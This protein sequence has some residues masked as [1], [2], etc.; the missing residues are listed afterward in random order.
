MKKARLI[1]T[2]PKMVIATE[3]LLC[4]EIINPH[5]LSL[6]HLSFLYVGAAAQSFWTQTVINLVICRSPNINNRLL[7]AFIYEGLAYFI[8]CL[9]LSELLSLQIRVKF[10]LSISSGQID[11]GIRNQASQHCEDKNELYYTN[12][13]LNFSKSRPFCLYNLHNPLPL[14]TTQVI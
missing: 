13:A 12:R 10:N 11:H 14:I 6:S 9:G 1:G 2:R 4:L 8:K 7:F 3:M 5:R